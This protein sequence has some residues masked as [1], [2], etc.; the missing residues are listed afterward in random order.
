[1]L[2]SSPDGPICIRIMTDSDI[3][4]S[5][6]RL[7]LSLHLRSVVRP[8]HDLLL[9]L[10]LPAQGSSH[11]TIP[12]HIR[13]WGPI[14]WLLST[15]I[16]LIRARAKGAALSTATNWLFN[17]VLAFVTPPLY[18]VMHGGF[19]FLLFTSCALSGIVVY[20]K[21]PETRG[22]TLEELG[23]VFG[24]QAIVE[25]VHDKVAAVHEEGT[26]IV[27]RELGVN[28]RM[29]PE[30]EVGGDP[31]GIESVVLIPAR[32]N[33]PGG[34]ETESEELLLGEETLMFRDDNE[35]REDKRS[36]MSSTTTNLT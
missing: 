17:F 16:F 11:F 25:T 27:N 34:P 7:R 2:V 28:G 4:L 30:D 31:A 12:I 24:D 20:Y 36:S 3:S 18:S 14:P 32:P 19:Y 15:E 29:E 33:G 35:I 21:Y 1:M 8:S 22:R 26:Q 9:H 23:E 5:K 6:S 10:I 13:R